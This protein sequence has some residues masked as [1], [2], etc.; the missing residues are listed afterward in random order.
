MNYNM[1]ITVLYQIYPNLTYFSVSNSFEE[2]WQILIRGRKDVYFCTFCRTDTVFH[3]I[4]D[5]EE[6]KELILGKA[7]LSKYLLWFLHLQEKHTV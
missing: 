6:V 7:Y 5:V 3:T 1:S 4:N 2:I